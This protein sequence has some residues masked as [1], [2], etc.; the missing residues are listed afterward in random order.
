MD[1][2]DIYIFHWHAKLTD[3]TIIH[4]FDETGEHSFKEVQERQDDL[5]YFWLEYTGPGNE[6]FI[7]GVDL[8]NG[9]FNINDFVLDCL[10][11]DSDWTP[12]NPE[13][14]VI[15]FRR[16]RHHFNQSFEETGMDIDYFIGWQTTFEGKNYKKLLRVRPDLSFAV[17]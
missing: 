10:K 13:L 7:V 12:L 16:I 17:S 3:G 6:P 15:N 5:V 8:V 11:E 2:K 14:R 1:N 4:Q 9:S